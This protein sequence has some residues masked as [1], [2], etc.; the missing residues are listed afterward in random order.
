MGKLARVTS[1]SQRSGRDQTQNA[2]ARA[3]AGRTA[4]GA[5]ILDLTVS[6][7]TVAGITYDPEV[8]EALAGAGDARYEPSPRGLP[9][10]RE[11]IAHEVTA[12]LPGGPVVT[13]DQIVLTASSSESYGFLFKL[14]CDPGDAVLVPT[15]SYPL[16]ELLAELDG[17]RL[18]PYR[19]AWD[20]GWHLD[21]GSLADAADERSRA[22]VSVAP[23]NPTG[24]SPTRRELRAMAAL[25]LPIISDEV[26]AGYRLARSRG[27]EYSPALSALELED[28]LV[29]ALGGL[30]KHVGLPQLKLGWI[31]VSGPEAARREALARLELIADTYLSV[32]TPVQRALPEI[33]RAGA[34]T[35]GAIGDRVRRNL[36]TLRR[37]M[38]A[39]P[40][41]AVLPVDGGWYALIRVPKTEPDMAWA[42]RLVEERGVLTHPGELFGIAHGAHLVVSLLTPEAPFAEGAAVIAEA[43]GQ[44]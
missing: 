8:F 35:R 23:N 43:V 1:F 29:F 41:A 11:A 37:T 9:S 10:A 19:L 4:R 39:A 31:V 14:L 22:V 16:F 18:S 2:L 26:F 28:T 15:P 7:P 24:S 34:A 3:C 30:S 27:G 17:V 40:A 32:A 20:G 33:L 25:G 44:A 36:A 5:P 13:A 42:V 21:L 38:A 6:N 12:G